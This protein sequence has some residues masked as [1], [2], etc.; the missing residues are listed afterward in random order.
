MYCA[1]R[2]DVKGVGVQARL[3]LLGAATVI[4]VGAGG[5]LLSGTRVDERDILWLAGRPVTAQEADVCARYL[6]RHRVHRV[7]GG[8]FGIAFAVVL[9]L[10]WGGPGVVIGDDPLADLWLCGVAGVVVGALSAETYRLRL[11]RSAPATASLAP[12]PA[13]PMRREV[14][15]AWA[16]VAAGALAGVPGVVAGGDLVGLRAAVLGA[17]VLGAG[18]AARSAIAYRRRPVLSER[19]LELDG[20]MRGFAAA[21]V[22]RLQVSLGTM[23]LAWSIWSIPDLSG[24]LPGFVLGVAS[25]GALVVAIHYLRRAAPRPPAGWGGATLPR[26]SP[27]A[28]A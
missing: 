20:R 4:L 2:P 7:V 15:V 12:R 14:V 21:S 27:A 6:R 1:N 18:A 16:L 24:T 9:S 10:R 8:L 23:V 17:L 25:L 22:A 11:P 28:S 19:A 13:L 3:L 26:T 5:L